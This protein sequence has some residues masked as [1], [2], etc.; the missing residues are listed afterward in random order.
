MSNPNTS[1]TN[2]NS[3]N[4]GMIKD[5][6]DSFVSEGFW[7]HARNAVNN[8][9]LGDQGVIGNEPSNTLCN[10]APYTIINAVYM[11]NARWV[12]FSTNNIS[13]EIGVFD[14]KICSYTKVVN[15]PCLN[16]K[17]EH[18]ITGVAKENADCTWS[19]YFQD[20]NNPDRYL[21][22]DN[23][24][25]KYTL[26]NTGTLDDPCYEKV[27]TNELDCDKILLHPHI[28]H[29]CLRLEKGTGSGQLPNGSYQAV[30]AYTVNGIRVTDY[31][32]PTNQQSLF[33]HT[34]VAGSLEVNIDQI[35]TDFD[36]FE[37][38]MIGFINQ[39]MTARKIG[40]YST[41]QK[42]VSI[43]NYSQSLP[44][45]PLSQI[46]LITPIWEKSDKMFE[47]AGYLLRSGV[48]TKPD[49]NYQQL[50]NNI[51]AKWV[52]VEYPADYYYKGGNLTGY[53]RDEVY[54]FF[55]R[56][57]YK[58][59]HKSASY[60]IP[61]RAP[62]A[63]D[64]VAPGNS[65]DVLDLVNEQQNWK[66]YNTAKFTGT[67]STLAAP[68]QGVVIAE[69]DMG[70]WEST[71][72]YPDDKP[73]IWGNLCGHNVRHH[74]MPDNFVDGSDVTHI[75]NAGGNKLRIL[76][77]RFDNIEHPKDLSGNYITDIVGYE[78]LRGT[79]EGNRTIIAKGMINNM[80][81]YDDL[82]TPNIKG[83][84]QNYPFNNLG[85]DVYHRKFTNINDYIKSGGATDDTSNPLTGV[86][87][88][89][90]TFHGAETNFRNPY[91]NPYEL[92][93][94]A[95]ESGTVRGSFKEVY[96]HPKVKMLTNFAAGLSTALAAAVVA[97]AVV[98]ETP[99]TLKGDVDLL[100]T[101]GTSTLNS[102]GTNAP[103]TI[104]Q[105]IFA[106]A[107][108][109][110][111]AQLIDEQ[112]AD[113][114]YKFVKHKQYALQ[115]DSH[116]F[117][118]NA[119]APRV[120]HTRRRVDNTSYVDTGIFPFGTNTKINN[121][122]RNRT[123]AVDVNKDI[124][125]PTVSDNSLV[126]MGASG[127]KIGEE[128]TR[129]T[130]AY[131]ASLKV[132][133]D[134][135][136][137]QIESIVQLP[138]GCVYSTAPTVN[139]LSSP[140]LFGG[141][142]Y[143][144]RYT[145]KNTMFFFNANACTLPDGAEFDYR[146]YTN[147]PFPRYW[148]D[149]SRFEG[150]VA[151]ILTGQGLP[152][153]FRHLNDT[154][155]G[156]GIFSVSNRYFYL[157]NS[158]VRDFFVE[159]E[160]NLAH[161]DWGDMI[162]ERHYDPSRYTD[163]DQLFRSDV[164]ASGNYYKY[165]YSLSISKTFNGYGGSWGFVLD[166]SYDP[167]VAASC[168]AYR[169][170]R[171][172][173]SLEQQKELK[174]DNWR[175][176]LA[177]NYKEMDGVVNTIRPMNKTGAI[178]LYQDKEPAMF[179]GVDQ[180]QTEGGIKFTIGDGGL[181]NQPLQTLVNADNNLEYGACQSH[182]SV[183]NTPFGLFYASQK[184]GKVF[185]YAGQLNEISNDGMKHWF[186]E[187]LPSKLLQRYPDFALADNPVAGIGVQSVYDPQYQMLYFTK[188]DYVVKDERIKYTR[189][190]GFYKEREII[191]SIPG[192]D[193]YSCPTGF[194]LKYDSNGAPFCE[195]VE[196]ANATIAF[197]EYDLQVTTNTAWGF[198]NPVIYDSGFNIGGWG[199]NGTYQNGFTRI[200]NNWWKSVAGVGG[201]INQIA[202][203]ATS[204]PDNTWLGF[205]TQICVTETKT[206]Y[207]AIAA[208]DT[209]RVKVDGVT[210]LDPEGTQANYAQ[211]K[212]NLFAPGD[213]NSEYVNFIHMHIY[214]IAITAGNHL[215]QMEY[216]N[217]SPGSPVMI[218]AEIYDNTATQ[219]ANATSIN[220]LT[221]LWSTGNQTVIKNITSI[222]CPSGFNISAS[223]TCDAPGCRKVTTQSATVTPGE[224][225]EIVVLKKDYIK[226][227]DP[228]YFDSCNWTISYDPKTK[229]WISFHDWH[230]TLVMPSF[231]HF[232]TVLG[233]TI[234][235]HNDN[236]ASYCKF[237][238]VDYPFEVELLT[239]TGQSVTTVRNFEYVLESYDYAG[240][241]DNPHHL[242][243]H[244]FDQAIVHN[245]EQISGMLNLTLKPKNNPTALLGY[246][247]VGATG[248]EILY[249]K[250]EN[251][252]RFNQFWDVTKDR[253]EFSGAKLP[254]LLTAC[255]GYVRTINPDA[256]NYNK[257][258]LERKKFRHYVDRLMLIRSISGSVK[259]LLKLTNTKKLFSPR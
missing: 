72:R 78:I 130:S 65:D 33:D 35:D 122:F 30:I 194:V 175:V 137:G 41:R 202:K 147:I 59:G 142:V 211:W 213:T 38:V 83:L 118:D 173:Y 208:D 170:K 3:F 191:G 32:T 236:C 128:L 81:E 63:D 106:G 188:R 214:P 133:Y 187:H 169:P 49:F 124:A 61:G 259:M 197:D 180:L 9:H 57:V 12:L 155:G 234:W 243:D 131:Y 160:I 19:V 74:K 45:V 165:D 174:K 205:T 116:G 11:T 193:T 255:N 109:V 123:V 67:G 185:Q 157:F 87:R 77:V 100:I 221:V 216:K 14:E 189:Q 76:G 121:L 164:I 251:K 254:L 177:L 227:G 209:F 156:D 114:L 171:V 143:V 26:V 229:M 103:Q 93:I 217:I 256:V 195:K 37:L 1:L 102:M 22:I 84:Y 233:N 99:T 97:N 258:P 91:L 246:P 34:N 112:I 184:Q 10:Q 92:K 183:V 98:S 159:S 25:F 8:S 24:P 75:H 46:P 154:N 71:E 244:N 23:V 68:Q 176:F 39:S 162:S 201:R 95:E 52:S 138:I 232:L 196:Y 218:A 242:L 161:R 247:K 21:N 80:R 224:P 152:S 43:D 53:M 126:T 222:T 239:N 140:I 89:I 36:E 219:I 179:Q 141:D 16:F 248:I 48:S 117:Y 203:K 200:T 101:P 136:Y 86:R 119:K 158:G 190:D 199:G 257:A 212:A 105:G 29:P 163:L 96:Q 223:S 42:V 166:R 4:K 181:F 245:S 231:N 66:V 125:D 215:V 88:D 55:I 64:L 69:G 148:L 13:S 192:P 149:S 90:F 235:R 238:G 28:V 240:G 73:N 56:W 113:L 44:V 139:K 50:A 120:T 168:Y 108:L 206:Y 250:E 230:P 104:A 182:R 237:Y 252:Y 127:K 62:V 58:T 111:A 178:V 207:L 228:T 241:C 144:N 15:D 70:Y 249:S 79:R 31:F 129:T 60:H 225:T 47:T 107:G 186:A 145:E 135:Q 134:N 2:T 198:V 82:I 7:L 153:R 85:A 27:Y 20:G 132:N 204:A 151:G 115:F 17:K 94:H 172:M 210:I 5:I 253:G 6:N 226:L 18:M 146:Q 167:Q 40:N 110:A 150:M 54:S 51:K 220:D